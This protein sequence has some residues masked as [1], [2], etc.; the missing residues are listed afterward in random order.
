[1]GFGAKLDATDSAREVP[2]NVISSS[3]RTVKSVFENVALVT[4]IQ[5]LCFFVMVSL[6]KMIHLATVVP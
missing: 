2:R 6:A 4:Q 3:A 5:P 1:M